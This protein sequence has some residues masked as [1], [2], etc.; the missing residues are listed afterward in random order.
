VVAHQ[1][2]GQAKQ[3]RDLSADPDAKRTAF[4]RKA[5]SIPMIADNR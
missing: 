2:Q 5:D 4:R 1:A 3:G